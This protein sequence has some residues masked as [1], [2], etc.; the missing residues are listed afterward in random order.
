LD[1]Y[2]KSLPAKLAAP[3]E[4]LA[5][6][7]QS[8]ELLQGFTQDRE[9]LLFALHHLPASVPYKLTMSGFGAERFV[10]SVD[11]IQQIVVQNEGISG[12]KN[13]YW[14]GTG[15]P[16]ISPRFI[17]GDGTEALKRYV[18]ETTNMLVEQ[19][20]TLFV[21][22]PGLRPRVGTGLVEG[23]FAAG[24]NP[25]SSEVSF[26]AIVNE[27]GGALYYNRNDI[28][29]ELGRSQLKGSQFYT[30]TYQP[31]NSMDDGKFRRIRVDVKRNGYRTLTKEGYFDAEKNEVV[32]PRRQQIIKL[33]TAARSTIP[34]TG[35]PLKVSRIVRHPDAQTV[36]VSF[37]VPAAKLRWQPGD[38]GTSRATIRLAAAG[39]SRSP[40]P[41][42]WK[43]EDFGLKT[44]T[45]DPQQLAKGI[46][47]VSFTVAYPAK[48]NRMRILLEPDDQGEIGSLDLSRKEIEVAQ[49][50]PT[51]AQPT[52]AAQAATSAAKP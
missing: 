27:T 3:A 35:I 44:G 38:P 18:H 13:I 41:V 24:G 43:V 28:A 21:Y 22:Y 46:V 37:L 14:L 30:L 23:N 5:L 47:P 29:E 48:L 52:P 50:L 10:Q 32:D 42:V 1:R 36:E 9:E 49:A 45:V 19:R 12:R 11:A 8:L 7:N 2:F 15:G 25:F 17:I 6:G 31:Q 4:L 51:P 34:M 16:S 33:G 39:F 20:I 40:H 26:G